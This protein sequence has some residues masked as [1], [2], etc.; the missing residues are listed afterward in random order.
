M[1]RSIRSR[2]A[3]PIPKPYYIPDAIKQVVKKNLDMMLGNGEGQMQKVLTFESMAGNSGLWKGISCATANFY[4]D[5][6]TGEIK[7]FGNLGE[8]PKDI[9]KK[10]QRH[11]FRLAMDCKEEKEKIVT[12]SNPKIATAVAQ[13][14]LAETVRQYNEKYGF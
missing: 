4:F 11:S 3:D 10:F 13:I 14:T 12:Y 2:Q 5:I 8:V 1:Y 6:Y 7:Y 9:P